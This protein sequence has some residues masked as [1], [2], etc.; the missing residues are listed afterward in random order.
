[1]SLA[2][3]LL[4]AV[5]LSAP[6]EQEPEPAAALPGATKAER[7]AA[8]ATSQ[9]QAKI[10][11]IEKDLRTATDHL[12]TLKRER[13]GKRFKDGAAKRAAVK[14]ATSKI[15]NLKETL[16][17]TKNQVHFVPDIMFGGLKIGD[18]G[19]FV[20][21]PSNWAKVFQ[22][23][24]DDE[25]MIEFWRI[26]RT[27]ISTGPRES[28]FLTRHRIRY[29]EKNVRDRIVWFRGIDTAAL[30]DGASFKPAGLFEI[31]GTTTYPTAI[32]GSNTILVAERFVLP[33]KSRRPESP[34]AT[35]PRP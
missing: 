16:R 15:K 27:A 8:Q 35:E 32:G 11:Q 5:L 17:A 23:V 31:T 29:K 3:S 34:E 21:R 9:K 1:M 20:P 18:M 14:A 7:Y 4:I 25:A 12:A 2:N 33:E 19:E 26:V 22:V 28:R 24:D 30:T 13:V 10:D 6:T